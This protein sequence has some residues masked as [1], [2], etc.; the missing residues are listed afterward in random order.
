MTTLT[1][2]EP[3]REMATLRNTLDRFFA[4]PF[5]PTLTWPWR[6]DE[7]NMI[8]DV[9][10]DEGAYIVKAELP[11][12]KPEDVEVTLNNHILTIK[13]EVKE[14]KATKEAD[15]HLRER[16]FGSFMRSLTMPAEIKTEAIEA[17]NEHGVLTI[18]LPKAEEVK[19]KKITVKTNG[20]NS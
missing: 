4:E 20:K 6:P 12:V 17:K 10:E 11:G 2:W 15:Y 8:V 16:R 7:F 19:P 18:R 1:R 9:A 3:W 5:E 14:E 13:G